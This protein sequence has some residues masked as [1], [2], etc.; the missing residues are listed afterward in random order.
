MEFADTLGLVAFLYQ[1]ILD[2]EIEC[3]KALMYD[4]LSFDL[5]FSFKFHSKVIFLAF[6]H[7]QGLLSA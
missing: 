4:V 5:F 7:F 2:C 6:G 1:T 3:I